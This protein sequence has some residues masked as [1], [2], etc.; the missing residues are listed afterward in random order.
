MK[1]F[2]LLSVLFICSLSESL[3]QNFQQLDDAT[4]IVF[5]VPYA[6]QQPFIDSMFV[7]LR[8]ADL[9]QLVGPGEVALERTI[10][11]KH[12]H[13]HYGVVAHYDADHVLL[14]IYSTLTSQS[15]HRSDIIAAIHA[16]LLDVCKPL[17][18]KPT[19]GYSSR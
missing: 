17:K 7:E 2:V 18:R 14:R 8:N 9:R 5:S 11:Y 1:H 4:A 15:K 10:I 19:L 6:Q 13:I 16:D 12:D 3:S